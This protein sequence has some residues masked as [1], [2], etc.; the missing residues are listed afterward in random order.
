MRDAGGLARSSLLWAASGEM[1]PF[2]K[3]VGCVAAGYRATPHNLVC[4]RLD[5]QTRVSLVTGCPGQVSARPAPDGT[6]CWRSQTAGSLIMFARQDAISDCA[7]SAEEGMLNMPEKS[8]WPEL[9]GANAEESKAQLAAETGC[10]VYLVETGSVITMDYR[11]DRIR[12]W[13][14]KDTGNIVRAPKVG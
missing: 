7:D 6:I 8:E 9:V 12:I 5:N 2:C 3:R 4:R 10:K 1:V 11:T 13:Y 14:D